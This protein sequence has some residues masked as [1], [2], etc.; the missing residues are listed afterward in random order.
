MRLISI[1]LS[2]YRQFKEP[3]TLLFPLGLTGICGPNGVGKSKLVEAIGYALYGPRGLLPTG[4]TA[5]DIP[6]YGAENATPMVT[7]T[8]AVGDQEFEVVR[9]SQNRKCQIRIKGASTPL[10]TTPRGVNAKVIELLRLTPDAFLGTF[11]ARQREVAALQAAPSANRQKLVNRLIGV[12][13]VEKALDMAQ[14]K[15]EADAGKHETAKASAGETVADINTRLNAHRIELKD[16]EDGLAEALSESEKGKILFTSAKAVFDSVGDASKATE[17]KEGELAV[18]DDLLSTMDSTVTTLRNQVSAADKARAETDDAYATVVR[19]AS[20]VLDLPM[21]DSLAELNRVRQEIETHDGRL[22]NELLVK[23]A[24]RTPVLSAVD[25]LSTEIDDN[26]NETT[27][28]QTQRG[29]EKARLVTIREEVARFDY[30][31]ANVREIGETGVC[32]ACGQRLGN[33]L[34]NALQHLNGEKGKAQERAKSIAVH[35]EEIDRQLHALA[36]ALEALRQRQLS[37]TN[38]LGQYEPIERERVIAESRLAGLRISEQG[39]PPEIRSMAYDAVVHDRLRDSR[40][41]RDKAQLTIAQNGPIL[42][43]ARSAQDSLNSHVARRAERLDERQHL[44]GE[45]DRLRPAPGAYETAQ[46]AFAGAQASLDQLNDVLREAEISVSN[47]KVRVEES[48]AQLIRAQSLWDNVESLRVQVAVSS[49]VEGLMRQLLTEI[50]VEARPRITELMEG[51]ARSLMGP[52]FKSICLTDDYRI[53]ADNGSGLHQI[54]HFSGGEQTLLAVM[55]RVAISIYCQERVGFPAGFLILD[56]VFG[57][58]DELHRAQLV[59]F[60]NEIKPN[61]H[62]ILVVNHVADVT[63]MLDSIISVTPTGEKTSTAAHLG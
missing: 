18:I 22:H 38:Q 40:D 57:D 50:T 6:S 44:S 39:Y 62:Q 27:V 31:I 8:I 45:I 24:E 51:W 41:T 11:V 9:T 47:A 17:Q 28:L 21:Y 3:V 12:S 13:L 63:G 56:E 25:A 52:Q 58:Q 54:E 4:D 61:Y 2:A 15:R 7:L 42:T 60:L 37:A 36:A 53:Q 43:L 30:Q 29:S 14:K 33:N 10:A 48:E 26:R 20:D 46:A 5:N 23:L 16:A 34:Q 55:L 35:I 19:C 32:T 59:Q 1:S 49:T